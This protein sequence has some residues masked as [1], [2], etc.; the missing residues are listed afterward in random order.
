[1]KISIEELNALRTNATALLICGYVE[2]K[3]QFFPKTS[4]HHTQICVRVTVVSDPGSKS[5]HPFGLMS[6]PKY[7]YAD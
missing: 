5:V 6:Y 2:Y 4:L 1:V 7:N 3:D